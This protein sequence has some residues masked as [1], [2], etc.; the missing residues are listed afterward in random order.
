MK[1]IKQMIVSAILIAFFVASISNTAVAQAATLKISNTKLVLEVGQ[2]K[3]LKITGTT[4]N[5]T[6]SSS[7]KSIATVSSKGKVTAV[8][9]GSATITAKTGDKKLTCKVTVIKSNP[10][11]AKAPFN[12]EE[13]QI[14]DINFII[15]LDWEV[16]NQDLGNG[17][18]YTE[19]IPPSNSELQSIIRI[20]IRKQESAPSDYEAFKEAFKGSYTKALLTTQWKEVF[21]ATKFDLKDLKQT[22]FT[23]PFNTVL[24]T[25]YSV[26]ASGTVVEQTLYD[27]YIGEYIISL[28]A[29]DYDG[30]DLA[31]IT[32]YVV[33]SFVVK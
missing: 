18:I 14:G 13:T 29:E 21:G 28:K 1:R 17:Y 9:T 32:D 16:N 7:K 25:Q 27:F 26:K 4:K 10:Y 6:W 30:M 33:S 2:T 22:D 5:V 20:D 11:L 23:A 15:P 8:A 3:S 19:I 31:A 24:R 12:A